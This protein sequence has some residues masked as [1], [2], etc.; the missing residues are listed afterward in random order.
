MRARVR[1]RKTDRG[2]EN[3]RARER[4]RESER[5]LLSP[6]AGPVGSGAAA[7]ARHRME[8]IDP[9]WAAQSVMHVR[10]GAR[11]AARGT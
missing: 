7:Q 2:R 9:R 10:D 11:V 3:G 8:M 5:E 6:V 1:E 4:A